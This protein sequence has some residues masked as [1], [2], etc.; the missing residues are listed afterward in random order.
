MHP[1]PGHAHHPSGPAAEHR[2][3]PDQPDDGAFGAQWWERHYQELDST[4]AGR[5]SP[6]LADGLDHTAPGTALDAGCGTG[7]DARW[8]AA[9]GWDVTAV[10]ISPTAIDRARSLT[11]GSAAGTISWVVADLTEWD[12][13]RQFDLV[14]SQY[15][16]P[17][18]PFEQFVRRLGQ[19]VADGGR[20]LVVGHEHADPR[21]AAGAPRDASITAVAIAAVLDR[22]GWSV[23]VAETRARDVGHQDSLVDTV[24]RA[25]KAARP[26]PPVRPPGG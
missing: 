13:A 23:E 18:Q 7:A 21:S 20:L 14:L 2:H 8:L 9:R 11:A 25:R 5:P 22:D 19:L 1:D 6:Y 4:P 24:V 17:D 10:D 26:G 16:H 3:S 12:P 15:A